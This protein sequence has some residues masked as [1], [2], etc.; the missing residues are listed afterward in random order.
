MISQAHAF[1]LEGKGKG[2]MNLACVNPVAVLGKDKKENLT[3][4]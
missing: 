3:M 4:M 2:K 1:V